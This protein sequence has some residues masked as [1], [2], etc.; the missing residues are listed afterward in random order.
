MSKIDFTQYR[1]VAHIIE[2]I[3]SIRIQGATNVAIATFEGLKLYISQVAAANGKKINLDGSVDFLSPFSPDDIWNTAY[4]LADARPNEPLAH[5]GIRFIQHY[6]SQN[7]VGASSAPG[8]YVS[9]VNEACESYLDLIK[10]SKEKIVEN[11][12]PILKGVNEILTH[13]HSSTA[14][15]V[16]IEHSKKTPDLITVCTET[17]PLYQGRITAKV[18]SEA[19]VRTIM[20]VDSAAE[21]FIIGRGL[22]NI[23]VVFIGCDEITMQGDVINKIGS[24]GLLLA[25]KQVGVPVYVITSILK[26][27]PETAHK[28]PVIEMRQAKEIWPD[29]PVGVE[30]VNPSFELANHDMVTGFITEAGIIKPEEIEST[31]RKSYQWLF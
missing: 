7:G 30:L 10:H 1:S 9:I 23:D 12:Q 17:R 21:S 20:I 14:E 31:L 26:T 29:A 2:D 19:G 15:K 11:A 6:L 3:K 28:A 25:A 8:E 27:N 4:Q 16:I 13:C 24:W 5:N 18:L 22:V